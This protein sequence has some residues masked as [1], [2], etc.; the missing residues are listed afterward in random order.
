MTLKK[1]QLMN[2]DTN[3]DILIGFRSEQQFGFKFMVS[4]EFA[5]LPKTND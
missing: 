3:L 4:G 1:L 5:L 2:R